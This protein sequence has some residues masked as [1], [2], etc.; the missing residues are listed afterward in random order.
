MFLLQGFT[1][2]WFELCRSK[3]GWRNS[4]WLDVAATVLPMLKWVRTYNVRQNLLVS[5]CLLLNMYICNP[6][7]HAAHLKCSSSVVPSCLRPGCKHSSAL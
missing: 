2:H 3:A 7:K 5:P 4:S 6:A 1:Q